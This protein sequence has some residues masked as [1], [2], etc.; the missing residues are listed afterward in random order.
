M[1]MNIFVPNVEQIKKQTTTCSL[2]NWRTGTIG[3][4]Q[5]IFVEGWR[6]VGQEVIC[7]CFLP[8]RSPSGPLGT[9][10]VLSLA[11]QLSLLHINV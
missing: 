7:F 6:T 1:A 9:A 10:D 2:Q 4:S 11:M 5:K 3:S 8:F